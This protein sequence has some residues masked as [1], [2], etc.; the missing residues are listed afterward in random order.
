MN[1]NT[2]LMKSKKQLKTIE[3]KS[4]KSDGQFYE[5]TRLGTSVTKEELSDEQQRYHQNLKN[6]QDAGKVKGC[7][8][9]GCDFTSGFF[10]HEQCN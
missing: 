5:V 10:T 2:I 9:C 6:T 3:I 4:Y 7:V 1:K 8:V